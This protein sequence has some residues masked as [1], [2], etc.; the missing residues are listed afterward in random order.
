[1]GGVG[2]AVIPWGP[3]CGGLLTGK[4]RRNDLS[5]EG[6]WKGG[7]DNFNREV[8]PKA[9]DVIEALIELAKERNCSPAQL[10]LAWNAAQP[11]I[12]APIIGPR[13]MQQLLDNL[14]AANVTLSAGDLARLDAV[15]PPMSSSL[16]YYDAAAGFD[17]KPNIHRW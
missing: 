16:R 8:T 1:V 13:T 6:R 7:K 17:L 5:A 15:A 2:L 4:Y 3:L 12:T 10:A 9:L 14:G 11:G